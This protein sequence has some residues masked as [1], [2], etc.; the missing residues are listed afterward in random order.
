MSKPINFQESNI[1]LKPA[2]PQDGELPIYLDN[3]NSLSCWK[4]S[5][6]ERIKALLF[7]RI[8]VCLMTHGKNQPAMWIHSGRTA[9]RNTRGEK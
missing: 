7:G 5:F 9:F 4:L 8:W 2:R 6:N 3:G 1:T